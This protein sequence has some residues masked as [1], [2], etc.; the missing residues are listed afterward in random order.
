MIAIVLSAI[1]TWLLPA[2]NYNTLH[3]E[4]SSNEFIINSGENQQRITASQKILDE[5]N[6]VISLDK[7]KEGKIKEK[8]KN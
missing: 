2:G 6:I 4:K 3:Y 5:K 7:F 8:Y 1:A